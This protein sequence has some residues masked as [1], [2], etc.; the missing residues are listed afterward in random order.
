M[1][2]PCPTLS[3]R[4]LNTNLSGPLDSLDLS[5]SGATAK[6][7]AIGTSELST[8]GLLVAGQHTVITGPAGSMNGLQATEF[9][10]RVR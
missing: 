5:T 9:Y 7:I 3:E 6:Q 4:S 2:Y 8:S 10:L 1:T